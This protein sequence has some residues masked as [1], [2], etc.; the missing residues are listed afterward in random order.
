[1]ICSFFGCLIFHLDCN[2]LSKL[3]IDELEQVYMLECPEL[4]NILFII[5]LLKLLTISLLHLLIG[6]YELYLY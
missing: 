6:F 3:K 2:Q 1:M 5:L 4:A